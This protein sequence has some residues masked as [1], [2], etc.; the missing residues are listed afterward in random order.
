MTFPFMPIGLPY[1]VIRTLTTVATATSATSTITIPAASRAGDLAIFIDSA[2]AD[3]GFNGGFTPPS[4]FTLFNSFPTSGGWTSN[5]TISTKILV[6]GDAGTIITGG[7]QT[8]MAK[9]LLIFRRN[10]GGII[11]GRSG[12]L[13]QDIS[14]ARAVSA[15][16][17]QATTLTTTT[18]PGLAIGIGLYNGATP[19]VATQTP[20]FGSSLSLTQTFVGWTIYN[21]GSTP[22][23][24]TISIG[25]NGNS[26]VVSSISLNI[27]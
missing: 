23:N 22:V 18:N 3:V 1:D 21:V 19:P 4:G 16:G 15:T 10:S 11:T 12:S 8:R 2:G 27:V 13:V 6:A 25:D 7:T 20:T 26:N 5:C 17:T 24:H 9:F 14:D